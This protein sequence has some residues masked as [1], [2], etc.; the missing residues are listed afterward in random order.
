MVF[1]ESPRRVLDT[2]EDMRSI[3][4]GERR[5]VLARELT[6]LFETVR[7]ASLDELIEFVAAD[8]NQRRGECVLLLEGAAPKSDDDCVEENEKL[9]EI[10]VN[11]LPL[12]QA[13]A[14]AVKITGMNK[15]L[16]YQT[17]LTLK[18]K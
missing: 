3:F 12:K 7:N 1:Y 14:I 13:V 8:E 9:L 18:D 10:L 4:G 15:N 2:L 5:A 17:A 6:K 16:L 11:E